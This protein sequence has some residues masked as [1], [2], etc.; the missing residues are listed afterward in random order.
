MR[1]LDL[2]T[3]VYNFLHV[4]VTHCDHLQGGM[5]EEYETN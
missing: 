2:C 5:Y 3:N 1:R 4:S